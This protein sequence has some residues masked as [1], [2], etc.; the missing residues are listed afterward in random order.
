ML[1]DDMLRSAP[2]DVLNKF[3]YGL[4]RDHVE[5][6]VRQYSTKPA[7]HLPSDLLVRYR[8]SFRNGLWAATAFKGATSSCALI[9]NVG[10]HVA[11]HLGWEEMLAQSHNQ[12]VFINGYILTGWQRYDHFASLCE[13]LPVAIPSLKCCL[14]ALQRGK[15]EREEVEEAKKILGT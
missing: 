8:S 5:L 6:L 4:I 1:W 14:I 2:M 3:E 11:N 15:F 12:S 10:V 13:F 9:P 7:E